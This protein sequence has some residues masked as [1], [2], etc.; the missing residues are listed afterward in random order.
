MLNITVKLT[1]GYEIPMISFRTWKTPGDV[2]ANRS[3]I[4]KKDMASSVLYYA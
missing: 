2:T 1:N 4:L 3:L